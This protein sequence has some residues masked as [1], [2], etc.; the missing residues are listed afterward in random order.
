MEN[1]LE[2]Q[3]LQKRIDDSKSVEERREL[4][5]F[6][7]PIPLAREIARQALSLMKGQGISFLEPAA[8]TGAFYSALLQ[9]IKDQRIVS[10]RGVEIDPAFAESSSHLWGASGFN[11]LCSDFTKA[12]PDG[13]YNL[14]LTNPPYVRNHL[15]PQADK[16]RLSSLVEDEL[17]LR[18][19]G[20]SGLYCYYL[21]LAHKWLAPGALCAWLLPSEF[22]DVN[23][24]AAVKDY[25]LHKV[26]LLRIHR[27]DPS[28][29]QFADALVSSCVVWFV[30]EAVKQDYEVEFTY[31]GTH[32]SPVQR[33]M[34]SRTVLENE[35]KW[36]RFPLKPSR[37]SNS[38]EDELGNFFSIKRGIAT[39]DN[40][41]FILSEE[42]I[43]ELG[44]DMKF[45]KPILPS[46]RNLKEDLVERD[47]NRYPK[48]ERKYFLLDCLAP[49]D[50]IKA[51]SPSLWS[52]IESG[53]PATS[54]KYLC[55]NRKKWYWQEQRSP[56]P[57]LCSYMGRGSA[58]SSPIRF[59]CNLSNAIATN[60]YLMLYPK[61]ALLRIIRSDPHA[62]I[63]IWNILKSIKAD[64]I[65][66]EGRVYGGGLKKI[67]PREL[68][69]VHC[70]EFE[71]MC[72]GA[73]DF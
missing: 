56:A 34:V 19:S 68:A 28:S 6:S 46:P 73:A 32:Q 48:L 4:G 17:G 16:A 27:Y 62:I 18:I 11:V 43:K 52:Y 47:K 69:R 12:S 39:G 60:S 33:M 64:D 54:A 50:Q 29:S 40:S 15:I 70:P 51:K 24:G 65:E 7:T 26:R 66:D 2:R 8:G 59:I 67:E 35:G 5:Q 30:N 49:E 22:M 21:L 61:E 42:R 13:K 1:E 3:A 55:R 10:A 58:K 45:F 36:T 53:V 9:E 14:V 25:L 20:L 72:A 71:R 31:G 44:L 37:S 23:Y 38:T 57:F 63:R 41:F